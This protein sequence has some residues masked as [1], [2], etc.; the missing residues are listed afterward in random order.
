MKKEKRDF[1]NMLKS[2]TKFFNKNLGKSQQ[3]TAFTLA[4]VLITLGIIG[5]V[6]AISI[7]TLMHSYKKHVLETKVKK[8]YSTWNQVYKTLQANQ[9]D[10][11]YSMIT[12]HYNADEIYNYF[13][14][15][16]TP[17]LRTVKTGKTTR[18]MYAFL[19]DG[20]GI[21]IAK[22]AY[23]ATNPG[24][25][26]YLN[27]CIKADDCVNMNETVAP[28]VAVDGAKTFNFYMTGSP[29]TYG[30][31][32]TRQWAFDRCNTG[33]K[34]VCTLLLYIDGWQ[35]KDDYPVKY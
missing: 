4:E 10:V 23:L 6:A 29:P 15:N 20:S 5:V 28:Y 21:Y 22:N 25:N 24:G 34:D 13:E 17:Y 31:D 3:Y 9:G 1:E 2:F 33:N 30:W 19:P 8:F 26:I 11:D 35:V 18:G 16:Y 14:V 32:G 7:P 12:T 27:Y